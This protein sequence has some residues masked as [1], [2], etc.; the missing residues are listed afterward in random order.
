MADHP[1][2]PAKFKSPEE[3]QVEIDKY[4]ADEEEP[5]KTMCGL[6][7]ALGFCDRQSIYD[8]AKREEYSCTIKAAMLRIEQGYEKRVNGTTPTGPI[9]VLKN[10]GWSDRQDVHL[11]SEP[12]LIVDEDGKS[13]MTFDS[14]ARKNE[15]SAS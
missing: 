3:M 14:K 11:T 13:L 9:F 4:F 1:G 8:Y 6:A 2:H 7:I 10:M 15:N 12:V 5:I